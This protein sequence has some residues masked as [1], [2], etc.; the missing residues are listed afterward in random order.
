MGPLRNL[1]VGTFGGPWHIQKARPMLSAGTPPPAGR[2]APRP[3]APGPGGPFVTAATSAARGPP[4]SRR[5]QSTPPPAPGTASGRNE[6][7]NLI[8][9]FRIQ[10]FP[11]SIIFKLNNLSLREKGKRPLSSAPPAAQSRHCGPDGERVL[12]APF[13]THARRRPLRLPRSA[14]TLAHGHTASVGLLSAPGGLGGDAGK[15]G[16]SG[17]A[18]RKD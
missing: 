13:H 12:N 11:H 6:K 16:R 15:P 2:P 18:A 10:H 3:R 1:A 14:E 17:K 7:G 8:N 5:T 4:A 9:S